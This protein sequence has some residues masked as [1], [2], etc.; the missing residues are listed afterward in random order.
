MLKQIQQYLE[1]EK[2]ECSRV[3]VTEQI[4]FD[5]LLVF[6]GLDGKKREQILEITAQEQIFN[7][8]GDKKGHVPVY[9]RLQFHYLFPFA[10]QDLALN[11]VGSLILFLNQMSDF[12]GL[13][14][15][16]L[17]NQISYR[18]I[19][20]AK[21]SGVDESLILSIIGIIKLTLELFTNSLERLAQGEV[22]FNDLLKEVVELGKP[23]KPPSS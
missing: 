11:Q 9:Y 16:E 23:A 15:N 18:Y 19:W 13:E 4:P 6:L 21:D 10:I 12:P 20:L 14:L 3:G 5:R 7:E 17:E 1:K 2:F 22:S 8:S